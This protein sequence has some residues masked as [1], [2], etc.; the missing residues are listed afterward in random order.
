[1]SGYKQAAGGA[2]DPPPWTFR[3]EVTICCPR[4][5]KLVTFHRSTLPDREHEGVMYDPGTI[6]RDATL[7]GE[8]EDWD[9]I[10]LKCGRC[11]ARPEI[12]RTRLEARLAA[13]WAPYAQASERVI[14]DAPGQGR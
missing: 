3:V 2:H 8:G 14:W 12:S 4:G 6:G 11:P 9:Q 1:V 7:T 5:H 13:M 10:C